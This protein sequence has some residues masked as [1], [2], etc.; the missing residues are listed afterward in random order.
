MRWQAPSGALAL[1]VRTVLV[2][3]LVLD[4]RWGRAARIH[5]YVAKVQPPRETTK[6]THPWIARGTARASDFFFVPGRFFAARQSPKNH[7]SS[8]FHDS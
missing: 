1:G 7:D 3:E 8:P 4:R 5:N 2:A 6:M